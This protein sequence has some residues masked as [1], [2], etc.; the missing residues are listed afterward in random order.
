MESQ[1][2]N[3]PLIAI[4]G[5][6]ASGKSALAMQLA[7]HFAGEIVCADSRTVYRGMDIGTAK[8]SAAER[9]LVPH[10]LLDVAEPS[11]RFTAADF[12]RLAEAAIQDIQRRG[13]V[14]FL[15]GGTGLYVDAVLYDFNFAGQP[16]LAQRAILQQLSVPALQNLLIERGIALPANSQNPRHLVRA[17][18]IG[19]QPA[20][21]QSLRPNTLV[22]GLRP[23]RRLLR[24]AVTARVDAMLSNGLIEEVR[25]LGAQYGWDA[26]ALQATGYKAFRQYLG[27]SIS[28]EEAKAQF[29]QNDMRLAKRQ[30]TWFR[31]NSDIHWLS[32]PAEAVELVTTFLNK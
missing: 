17:L 27:G 22:I 9:A 4:V 26:P 3:S 12:K 16:D 6:T 1:P 25:R 20:T 30:R 28:L 31:R 21:R 2:N 19:G 8:P 18:E 14:P 24:A 32:K 23:E 7:Q 10:H 5:E 11:E 29:V 15:V 13:R